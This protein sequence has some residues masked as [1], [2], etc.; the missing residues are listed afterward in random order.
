MPRF[1]KVPGVHLILDL[2][3]VILVSMD[4]SKAGPPYTLEITL[5]GSIVNSINFADVSEFAFVERELEI[6]L[7]GQGDRL[8]RDG[9]GPR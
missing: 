4:E 1:Y 9:I 3:Q 2:D 8:P 5:Y 6:A 7:T